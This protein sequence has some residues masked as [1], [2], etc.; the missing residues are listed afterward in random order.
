MKASVFS[1]SGEQR[2]GSQRA[3]ESGMKH[4]VIGVVMVVAMM[5]AGVT[6]AA[7]TTWD[8]S[9]PAEY[10]ASGSASTSGVVTATTS[11]LASV[12]ARINT[13]LPGLRL[14]DIVGGG[15]TINSF[16]TSVGSPAS[17]YG[18]LYLSPTG[19]SGS[20]VLILLSPMTITGSGT[21]DYTFDLSTR[22]DYRTWNNGWTAYDSARSGTFG[23]V[24][25]LLDTAGPGLTEFAAFFGPQIGMSETSGTAFNVTGITL[26]T[27]VPEPA[28]L[29]IWSLLGG[30]GIAVAHLRRKA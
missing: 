10:Y 26:D 14:G 16:T 25:S 13:K 21:L 3:K 2:D 27:T 17:V 30:L 19:G 29:I 12:F 23:Q 5:V 18:S 9:N 8:L 28:T 6:H 11:D 7:V 22:A 1:R 4:F 20:N 24:I 15:Y